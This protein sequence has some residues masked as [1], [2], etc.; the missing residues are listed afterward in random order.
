MRFRI[1]GQKEKSMEIS[2]IIPAVN[3]ADRIGG[4]VKRCLSLSPRPEVIVADGG[5]GDDTSSRAAAAGAPVVKSPRRGRAF[6]MNAGAA[7]SSGDTLV[8]LHADVNLDRLAH[9]ALREALE[10]PAVIGGAFRRRFDSP[11]PL[12]RAGCR[13]ADLRGR[14]LH[15]FL[16]DQALFVRREIHREMGGFREILLF[17]DLEFSRRLARRGKTRLL[18][19]VVIA[20]SRRFD[21]EGS[22]PRLGKDLFLA[23]L[24][25]AGA[26]PD[27]LARRYYPGYFS[28]SRPGAPEG[29]VPASPASG[30]DPR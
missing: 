19:A 21:R 11:S 3:E 27:L 22:L 12:L 25:L 5:S 6:Q 30:G 28:S 7:A 26:D 13:L 4:Q 2:F 16:G 18:D 9:D 20:S 23:A 14:W 8:F 24:Y 1:Q 15:L 29:S 17:E 10:D